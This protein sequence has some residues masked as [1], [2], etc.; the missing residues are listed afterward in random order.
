M[1][2]RYLLSALLT[3][4]FCCFMTSVDAQCTKTK[5]S[6]CTKSKTEQTKKSCS[7]SYEYTSCSKYKKSD[8]GKKNQ[9]ASSWNNMNT[10]VALGAVAFDNDNTNFATGL[11]YT[12]QV[13][14]NLGLGL[15]SEVTFGDVNSVKVGIPVSYYFGRLKVSAAP[16]GIF[17]KDV[18]NIIQSGGA[19][20]GI[21]GQVVEDI[22][23]NLGARAA[24]S[25]MMNVKGLIIAPTVRA[26]YLGDKVIPNVGINVGFGF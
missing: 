20:G 9:N 13:G 8:C 26:D 4:L 11:E 21:T 17:N 16:M 25:Y 3:M 18:N 24:V 23:M 10:I 19:D 6:S 2:N 7:K 14:D 12:R 1:K 15:L 22:E 5:K